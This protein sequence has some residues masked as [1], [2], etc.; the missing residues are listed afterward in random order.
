MAGLRCKIKCK[1]NSTKQSMAYIKENALTKKEGEIFVKGLRFGIRHTNEVLIKNLKR[2][3]E[4][5]I[6]EVI[7][8]AKKVINDILKGELV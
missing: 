4:T 5:T 1:M 8:G 6:P 3:P 2:R 7:A